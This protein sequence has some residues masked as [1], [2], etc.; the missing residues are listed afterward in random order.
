MIEQLIIQETYK[1]ISFRSLLPRI[2]LSA[3]LLVALFRALIG[4]HLAAIDTP[5][6]KLVQAW[7]V[8]SAAFAHNHWNLERRME[9]YKG[10]DLFSTHG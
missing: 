2:L 6:P 10:F 7:D 8:C 5:F 9:V 4:Q 1:L 3:L